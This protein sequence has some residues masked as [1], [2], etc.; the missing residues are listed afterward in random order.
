ML[1]RAAGPLAWSQL[2]LAV[3]QLQGLLRPGPPLWNEGCL[4]L[5]FF[6]LKSTGPREIHGAKE[7]EV[8]GTPLRSVQITGFCLKK[9]YCFENPRAPWIRH[10]GQRI[11]E[12]G[13][14]STV[15]D[16]GGPGAFRF[17]GC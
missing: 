13:V 14:R 3:S 4:D 9:K 7:S 2:S 8:G 10:P 5:W 17:L 11:Q 6:K 1:A 16:G 15:L 12:F